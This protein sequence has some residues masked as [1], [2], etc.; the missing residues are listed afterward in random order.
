[1]KRCPTCAAAYADGDVFCE[2]DGTKLPSIV[3]HD[4]G[5]PHAAAPGGSSAETPVLDGGDPHTPGTAAASPRSVSSPAFALCDA[6]GGENTDDGDGYCTVCGHRLGGAP[7]A[8]GDTPARPGGRDGGDPH[9]PGPAG[10]G[11][12]SLTPGTRLGN[13]MVRQSAGDRAT[14]STP[15]GSEV[16][17]VVGDARTLAHEADALAKVGPH[18]AFPSVV[19]REEGVG[20]AFLAISAPSNASRMLADVVQ[21]RTVEQTIAAI[22]GLLDLAEIV[23]KA[24]YSFTPSPSDLLL[25]PDGSVLLS[26]LR[27]ATP[28]HRGA[29]L[30]AHQLLESLAEIFLAP[31]ILGPTRLVRLLVPSRDPG[32]RSLTAVR[33]AVAAVNSELEVQLPRAAVCELCDPGLW[34]PYNQDSTAIDTGVT[35]G[36][37][38]FVVLVVCDGV[39]SSSFSERASQVAAR[40]ARDALG[41]FARSPDIA[42]DSAASAVAQAIRAAHL[43]ICVAHVAEPVNDP[44]GTTI[45]AALVF[46]KRLTVG[47][48]GDSRAY[49]L[50]PRGSELLTHDHS[51]VNEAIAR[52]EVKD[53]ERGRSG[54]RSPTTITKCSSARS[55]VG[56]IP[57]RSIEPRRPLARPGRPRHDRAPLQRRPVELLRAQGRRAHRR[58]HP[59]RAPTGRRPRPRSRGSSSTTRWRAAG[60]TTFRSRSTRTADTPESGDALAALINRRTP[61]G[62]RSKRSSLPLSRGGTNRASTPSSPSP[63]TSDA[64][65]RVDGELVVGFIVDKS[66]SMAGER[67]EAVHG[68]VAAGDLAPRR[69]RVVLRRG[70]RRRRAT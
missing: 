18:R 12:T 5:D 41:H 40:A 27:G 63:A 4:G 36:G 25:A 52:G 65:G 19:D 66:G 69:A 26:R 23:E 21:N 46:R 38:P 57:A 30:D 37:E 50:T 58:R 28:L 43:A 11:G 60:T 31:A 33:A 15:D 24:G 42:H 64:Q 6:C 20:G 56:D 1:M 16:L 17:L 39:S 47:W 13:Y 14:A 44:P 29:R 55:E 59:G 45:A 3:G 7:S 61:W 54:S 68:A 51:W 35:P 49:W 8:T 32:D 22:A 10:R 62:S 67:I 34:R 2:V 70:L 53:A 9:T 48:V